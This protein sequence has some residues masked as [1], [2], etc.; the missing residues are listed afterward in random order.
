[1]TRSIVFKL[2]K[3]QAVLLPKPVA[4]PGHVKRVDIVKHG[5][6]CLIMPEG[7]SWDSFFAGP[8]LDEDFL[9]DRMQPV[10]QSRRI[11]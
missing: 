7:G 9:A 6:G 8:R 2:N 5:S 11:V 3:T 4:L 1:M 10:L